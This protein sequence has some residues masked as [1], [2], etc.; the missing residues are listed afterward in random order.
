[1]QLIAHMYTR[2]VFI[3]LSFIFCIEEEEEGKKTCIELNLQESKLKD[4]RFHL[5]RPI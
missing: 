2:I 3:N 1:M 4:A 5:T